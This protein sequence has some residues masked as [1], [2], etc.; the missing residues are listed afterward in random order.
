MKIKFKNSKVFKLAQNRQLKDIQ[1]K[2]NS[3]VF[4]FQSI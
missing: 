2:D 4:E 1:K 3:I